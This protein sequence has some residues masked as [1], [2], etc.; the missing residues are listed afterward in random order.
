MSGK[1]DETVCS[2]KE[3][4][5]LIA[6]QIFLEDLESNKTTIKRPGISLKEILVSHLTA[7]TVYVL[8]LA[9]WFILGEK[10]EL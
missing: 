4:S 8:I 6:T 5:L 9:G 10:Y 1:Y 7:L 3:E 2:S